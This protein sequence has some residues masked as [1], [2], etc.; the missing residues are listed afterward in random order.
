MNALRVKTCM[1]YMYFKETSLISHASLE[2]SINQSINQSIRTNHMVT[3]KRCCTHCRENWGLE[4]EVP[5][6]GITAQ[7]LQVGRCCKTR[8]HRRNLSLLDDG[9]LLSEKFGT[10]ILGGKL[11][12]NWSHH[13]VRQRCVNGGPPGQLLGVQTYTMRQ[14]VWSWGLAVDEAMITRRF[15]GIESISMDLETVRLPRE[16][17]L[18]REELERWSV[19]IQGLRQ[20]P[21]HHLFVLIKSLSYPCRG[22]HGVLERRLVQPGHSVRNLCLTQ[23]QQRGPCSSLSLGRVDLEHSPGRSDRLPEGIILRSRNL[24]P[25]TLSILVLRKCSLGIH[26]QC[27]IKVEGRLIPCCGLHW[28]GSGEWGTWSGIPWLAVVPR[29]SH[30]RSRRSHGSPG[31]SVGLLGP[32]DKRTNRTLRSMEEPLWRLGSCWR[33]SRSGWSRVVWVT[34]RNR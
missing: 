11:F 6:K 34:F 19:I 3:F 23:V 25:V 4:I 13:R 29:S 28:R 15:R 10:L 1:L 18:Y 24:L 31:L 21:L 22:R 17:V 12:N 2:S 33:S 7:Q 9:Q 32:S 16:D 20:R 14:V 30:G 26:V 8:R 5:E 27:C